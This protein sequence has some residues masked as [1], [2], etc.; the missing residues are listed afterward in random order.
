MRAAPHEEELDLARAVAG[1]ARPGEE[2]LE[3]LDRL[4][5]AEE[6]ELETGTRFEHRV[7]LHAGRRDLERLGKRGER[8]VD[9]RQAAERSGAEAQ[10]A[11][12]PLGVV[13][14]EHV[15]R[16]VEIAER[17]LEGERV[18]RPL[19]GAHQPARRA[20]ARRGGARLVE[21]VGDLC[22]EAL[23]FL[24]VERFERVG[25]AQVEALAARGGEERQQ[26]LAD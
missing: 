3:V 1:R 26:G 24:P 17:V 15:A 12:R 20:L 2:G 19:G 14:R 23:R 9:A 18:E 4:A 22:G 25:H 6:V 5:A 13:G 21:V 7:A 16:A 11:C 8:L 10:D